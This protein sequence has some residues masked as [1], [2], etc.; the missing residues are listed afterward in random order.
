[1]KKMIKEK[2]FSVACQESL[3]DI[4]AKE[5]TGGNAMKRRAS[6]NKR[7]LSLLAGG[8]PRQRMKGN[9]HFLAQLET[10]GVFTI[11]NKTTEQVWFKPKG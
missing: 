3:D 6:A 1:M 5:K 9:G 10:E 2:C 7:L 11:S 4:V 8:Q